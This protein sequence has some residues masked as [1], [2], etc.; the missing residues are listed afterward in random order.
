ML[1]VFHF[2]FHTTKYTYTHTDL[3]AQKKIHLLKHVL[4]LTKTFAFT[5]SF[6]WM[7]KKSFCV[8]KN[9]VKTKSKYL[10]M[11]D[12]I[13]HFHFKVSFVCDSTGYWD[14]HFWIFSWNQF[15]KVRNENDF[16][17]ETI[18]NFAPAFFSKIPWNQNF[19]WIWRFFY[20]V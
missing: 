15:T 6:L 4:I 5:Y 16:F 13:V 3:Q 14:V 1:S 12:L 11:K 19:F 9:Y 20:F 17:R 18:F 10:E 7:N 2:F 8:S